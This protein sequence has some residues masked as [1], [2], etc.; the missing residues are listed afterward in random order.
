MTIA[1][2]SSLAA[3]FLHTIHTSEIALQSVSEEQAIESWRPGG[4]TRKQILGHLCDSALN[5]RLRIVRAILDGS[6]EGPGYDQNRWVNLHGYAD[7]SWGEIFELWRLENRMLGRVLSNAPASA[8]DVTIKVGAQKM[9]LT[10]LVVDDYL[11]HLAHH[12]KQIVAGK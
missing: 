4:W 7:L 11:G 6:Y 12:L 9:S 10:T 5:N 1:D 8:I 2:T 3:N